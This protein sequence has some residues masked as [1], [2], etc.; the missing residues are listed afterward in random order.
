[1]ATEQL[2]WDAITELRELHD[3]LD[4]LEQINSD[5]D[6]A[7]A[8]ECAQGHLHLVRNLIDPDRRMD[9]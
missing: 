6:V 7:T 3:D 8:I 5:P 1:M 9:R 2:L 4:E